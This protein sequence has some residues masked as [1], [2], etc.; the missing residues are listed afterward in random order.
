MLKKKLLLELFL[1]AALAALVAACSGKDVTPFPTSTP[2]P[3]PTATRSAVE[4]K[5]PIKAFPTSI[6]TPM[7]MP[8]N[9]PTTAPPTPQPVPTPSPTS[10]SAEKRISVEEARKIKSE[11][12][13]HLGRKA[14]AVYL[15]WFGKSKWTEWNHW[16]WSGAHPHD[17]KKFV[18]NDRRDVASVF[19]PLIGPYN[20]SDRRVMKYHMDLAKATGLDGFVVDW[21]GYRDLPSTDL[22][23]MDTNLSAM[24]DVAETED[25]QLALMYEP[26][27]HFN[28]WMPHNSRNESV[29]A[30]KEDL[31]YALKKYGNKKSFLTVEGVPVVFLFEAARLN[32]DEWEKVVTDLENDGLNA[33]LVGDNTNPQFYIACSGLAQWPDYEALAKDTTIPAVYTF[34]DKLLERLN[35]NNKG[36]KDRFAASYVWPGFNDTGVWGWN[37]GPRVLDRVNGQFYDA[38]WQASLDN[39]T[40]W[41]IAATWNDFNEGTNIEPDREH[42][43][44]YLKATASYIS[45]FKGVGI[46]VSRIEEI[47]REFMRSR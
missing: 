38:T 28:G 40:P 5:E 11:I 23:F 19:Y 41:I 46:D 36:K 24:M 43:H 4:T 42:G 29:Q 26:K 3:T 18:E 35:K 45:R 39:N 16:E 22:A 32:P 34:H 44:D 2:Q 30:V 37:G 47:T 21:Y 20:S 27:I 31:T 14:F 13:D 6:P 9:T 33:I 17:P 10:V 12:S 8:T 1:P 15:P 25:F 7:P